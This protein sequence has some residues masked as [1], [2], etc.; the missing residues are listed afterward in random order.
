MHFIQSK[1]PGVQATPIPRPRCWL[2]PSPEHVKINVGTAVARDGTYGAVGAIYRSEI[3]EFQGA[4]I[5]VFRSINDPRILES[6]AIRDAQALADDLYV[7]RISVASDCNVA[8]DAIK[9]GSGASFGAIIHEITSRASTFTN[10]IF[11]HEHGLA[12]GFGRHVWLGQPSD[13]I[14]IP[15]NILTT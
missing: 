10:C 12:L 11:S 6:P 13:L 4:S 8:M 14:F 15:V 3:G 5:V 1:T 7:N 9:D 2:P